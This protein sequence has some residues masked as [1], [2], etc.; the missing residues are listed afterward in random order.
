MQRAE[1]VVAE[2][3]AIPAHRHTFASTL[4][5]LDEIDNLLTEAS[6]GYGF[7]S[8]VAPDAATRDAAHA[9]EERLDTFAI[10]LGF[11]EEVYRAVL[12]FAETPEAQALD[13]VSAR[14]LEHTLRDFRRNGMELEPGQRAHVQD[15]MERLVGLGIQFRRNIDD[16]QDALLLTRDQLAGLPD[17]Y[18]NGLRTETVDG[19]TRYRVS[20]DYPELFPFLE[21]AED[22]AL[23]EELFRK[24]HNKAADANVPVLH[25]AIALRDEIATTLGYGSWAEYV[26][27][28]RMAKSPQAVQTFLVDLER[29]VAVKAR[30][31]WRRFRTCGPQAATARMLWKYGTGATTRSGCCASV[32]MWTR[33]PWRSTSRWTPFW[34][35]SS[36]F[37]RSW[38]ACASC[39]VMMRPYGIRTSTSST[40]WIW[41]TTGS[42]DTS[43]WTSTRV[44]ASLAMR[45]RSHCVVDATSRTAATNGP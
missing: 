36:T 5:A 34:T 10:G 37:I 23:R 43:I 16:F 29:R 14:L 39:P 22:R 27:E 3:S 9:W 35:A 28:I 18:I 20:L 15:C 31:V 33:S 4:L 41:T 26:L 30:R 42:L 13:P 19:Q 7:L 38:W 8:Q 2:I 21:A 44:Q 12:A 45:P 40:L 1:A 17:G 11:R 25:E 32:I 24:N 6:G